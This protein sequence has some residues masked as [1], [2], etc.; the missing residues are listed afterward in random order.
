MGGRLPLRRL[1][2][3]QT[4]GTG[5]STRP[6]R[7]DWQTQAASGEGPAGTFACVRADAAHRFAASIKHT[8]R[9]RRNQRAEASPEP[10]LRASS[11]G[12]P[13]QS[14][15]ETPR[16]TRMSSHGAPRRSGEP[17]R[18]RTP[19][20]APTP[21]SAGPPRPPPETRF[22]EPS[23]VSAAPGGHERTAAQRGPDRHR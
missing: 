7:I 19:R 9:R 8:H 20:D 10:R 1:G 4:D 3:P 6:P 22:L 23:R 16:L 15:T 14:E 5:S 11:A 13:R 21:G 17:G 2:G 18:P 12:R